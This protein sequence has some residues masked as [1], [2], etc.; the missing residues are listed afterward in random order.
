MSDAELHRRID[1]V[2]AKVDAVL[3]EVRNL[4][5]DMRQGFDKLDALSAET[6]QGFDKLDALSAETRQGFDK[7]SRKMDRVHDRLHTVEGKVDG[8]GTRIDGL[9]TRVETARPRPGSGVARGEN[10]FPG[11]S[12]LNP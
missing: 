9:G 3:V 1:A 6:R 2:D 5:A 12:P 7:L 10:P 8:L 11:R 4:A